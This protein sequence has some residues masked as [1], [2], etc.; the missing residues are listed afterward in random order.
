MKDWE[1]ASECGRL[2]F[3]LGTPLAFA[4]KD[5][6]SKRTHMSPKEIFEWLTQRANERPAVC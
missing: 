6:N 2:Y 5:Y 1:W 4:L 3:Q